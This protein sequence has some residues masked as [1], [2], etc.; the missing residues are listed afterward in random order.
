MGRGK[1]ERNPERGGGIGRGAMMHGRLASH[2]RALHQPQA[3]VPRSPVWRRGAPR[4]RRP[5][6]DSLP[7]TPTRR[8]QRRAQ[9]SP[10]SPA[11]QAR[12]P[13]PRLM[14]TPRPTSPPRPH[15]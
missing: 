4:Y 15:L 1:K 7:A 11:T 6:A 2:S 13:G 8:T 12:L 14:P 5:G 3:C 10:R 9:S